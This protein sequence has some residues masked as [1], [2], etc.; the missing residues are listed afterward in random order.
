MTTTAQT[1]TVVSSPL[2]SAAQAFSE[3]FR[4]HIVLWADGSLSIFHYENLDQAEPTSFV[5]LNQES[6]TALA[7]LLHG[8]ALQAVLA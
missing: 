5:K 4:T 6:V 2:A 7:S 3:D 1:S 8:S